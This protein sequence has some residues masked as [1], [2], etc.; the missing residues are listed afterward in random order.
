MNILNDADLQNCI[1]FQT[2]VEFWVEG[3]I[4]AVG[5]ICDF[6]EHM[7]KTI[8]REYYIRRNVLLKTSI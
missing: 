5:Y 4:D 6:N 8:T 1:Y 7:V 3:E 2:T